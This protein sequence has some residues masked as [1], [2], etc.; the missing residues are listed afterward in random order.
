MHRAIRNKSRWQRGLRFSSLFDV[1]VASDRFMYDR[2]GLWEAEG[3]GAPRRRNWVAQKKKKTSPKQIQTQGSASE[4]LVT[5]LTQQVNHA[6][7][8]ERFDP[9]QVQTSPAS[10]QL[11]LLWHQRRRHGGSC[12]QVSRRQSFLVV[13]WSVLQGWLSAVP[14]LRLPDDNTWAR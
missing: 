11:R 6:T 2:D 12:D 4:E 3:K 1:V 5:W 9:W 14:R 10:F 7:G 13:K 8:V